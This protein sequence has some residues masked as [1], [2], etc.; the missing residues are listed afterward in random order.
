MQPTCKMYPAL[1]KVRYYHATYLQEVSYARILL[2]KFIQAAFKKT[3]GLTNSCKVH[4]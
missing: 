2:V 3:I 4:E 1:D